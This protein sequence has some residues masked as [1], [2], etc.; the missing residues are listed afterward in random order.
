MRGYPL[1]E[2]ISTVSAGVCADVVEA[3]F[4]VT[5]PVQTHSC[6]VALIDR[7]AVVPPLDDTDALIS[8]APG[9]RIGVRTAD[10]VP[11]LLYAP[12]L[13]AVAAVH[14]GWKGTLGGI[15]TATVERLAALGASPS[16]M[17][18]AF[19]PSI[20]GDCYEVSQE[21]ADEFRRAGFA[22]CLAGERNV[23]LEAVNR[24]RLIDAGLLPENIS[25]SRFCTLT[26]P[27]LPSW[28]REAT[29]SRLLTW[30]ELNTLASCSV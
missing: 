5:I 11:L 26:T 17:K 2:G 29:T 4:V 14:A 6:N 22:D 13:E 16:M 10:C 27:W 25:V 12:D 21:L 9:V 15:V 8:L 7:D 1:F 30:I 3:P 28:R 20:C 23:S 24:C 19:G 18:A